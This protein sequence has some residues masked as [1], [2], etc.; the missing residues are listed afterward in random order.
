MPQYEQCIAVEHFGHLY[1]ELGDLD[2]AVEVE[3]EGSLIL[4]TWG[5]WGTRTEALHFSQELIHKPAA[6]AHLLT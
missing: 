1:T 5:G 6:Y 2:E 4:E 3:F